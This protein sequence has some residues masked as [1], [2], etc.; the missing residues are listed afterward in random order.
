MLILSVFI[1]NHKT[2]GL[3]GFS[4]ETFYFFDIWVLYTCPQFRLIGFVDTSYVGQKGTPYY[5]IPV[6]VP[7]KTPGFLKSPYEHLLL[8]L[9]PYLLPV[10]FHL[11]RTSQYKYSNTYFFSLPLSRISKSLQ[12]LSRTNTNGNLKGKT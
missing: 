10:T 12:E 11:T 7:T 2:V 5:T 4:V 9:L 3:V 8:L 6:H 1:A